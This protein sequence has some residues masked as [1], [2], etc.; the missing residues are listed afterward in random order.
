[1]TSAAPLWV[2]E[3]FADYV[4]VR[5]AGVATRVAAAAAVATMRADGTPSRLPTDR[6]FEA[7]GA[8][9]ESAYDLARLAI[10]TIDRDAGRRRLVAFYSAVVAHPRGLA[11]DWQ[12]YLGAPRAALTRQ[13]RR[14]LVRLAGAQ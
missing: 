2:T 11:G 10:Q 12:R 13:W 6:D 8:R 3:G 1:V 14:L 4:A 9:L 5:S 7:T